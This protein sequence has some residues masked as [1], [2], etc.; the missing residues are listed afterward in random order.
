LLTG[1]WSGHFDS[2]VKQQLIDTDLKS[3]GQFY[4]H[5]HREGDLVVFEAAYLAAIDLGMKSQLILGPVFSWRNCFDFFPS[6]MA[7]T[8]CLSE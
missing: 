8:S 6:G 1:S 7:D 3:L 4:H 5:F 2:V